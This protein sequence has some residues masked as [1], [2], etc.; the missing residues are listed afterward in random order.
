MTLKNQI[1]IELALEV[2]WK[3]DKNNQKYFGNKGIENFLSLV[4]GFFSN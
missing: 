1:L 2:I 3:S 4:E